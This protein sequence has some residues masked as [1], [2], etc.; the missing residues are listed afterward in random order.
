MLNQCR[1]NRL[2]LQGDPQHI[3]KQR[4]E[5]AI[6]VIIDLLRLIP[7][8]PSSPPIHDHLA[9]LLLRDPTGQPNS[10]LQRIDTYRAIRLQAGTS[11]KLS[12]KKAQQ[13]NPV[14]PERLIYLQTAVYTSG[15][16]PRR[17]YP[18]KRC[19]MRE[20]KRKQLKEANRKKQHSSESD[21]SAAKNPKPSIKGILPNAE[22][23][24]GENADQYEPLNRS[25]VVEEPVWDPH[26][27]DWRNEMVLFNST[28]EVT[29][30]KG[31][32]EWLPFRV[33]CYGKCHGE[34]LGF[35]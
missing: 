23:I 9:H 2:L 14:P 18:C 17:V 11:T 24:T 8:T 21:S 31:S 32:C 5:T 7:R 22:Y 26:T 20:L 30:K 4:V 19:R 34:K 27:Q 29:L 3:T 28:P 10:S 35:M 12:S 15:D 25:Q 1:I 33:I 16:N 6:R 13:A